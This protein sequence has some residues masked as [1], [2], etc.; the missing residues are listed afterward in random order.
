MTIVAG[1]VT[2]LL[3]SGA[4]RAQRPRLFEWRGMVL[5]AEARIAL[6]HHDRAEA[7]AAIGAVAA[8]IERLENEFSLY[9]PHSALSALNRDGM[10]DRPSLDMLR[11]LHESLRFGDLS[12]GA[13]DVT[14]QPLWRIYADHFAADPDDEAGPPASALAGARALI[15]YRRV[16]VAPDRIALESG[17][18]VTLNGIA[19]GY[20]TD[21]AADLLRSRGWSHVLIDLGEL[22]ALGGAA[23]GRPWTVGLR[24]PDDRERLLT[25]IP[26]NG[27]ALATSAGSGTRFDRLGHHHHLFVAATG[28]S[29]AEYASVSVIADRATT[30]DALSTA[31]FVMPREAAPDLLRRAGAEEAWLVG[32]DGAVERLKS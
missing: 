8:E 16:R 13:F 14:V 21:R 6:Y 20:I 32:R 27:R 28:R 29:G 23:D 5:G 7:A 18:A 17:M 30:A 12:S 31:V 9:R 22:R 10:L 3:M 2:A 24:D 4:A 11:L 19:Q 15:D 25:T 26:L 1:S